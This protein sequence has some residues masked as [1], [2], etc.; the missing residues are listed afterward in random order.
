MPSPNPNWKPGD[1]IDAPF[2]EQ[3]QVDPALVKP[4]DFYKLMIGSI[5]PRPIAFVSTRG[6]DGSCNLSPFSFFNGVSSDPACVIIAIS[7]KKHGEPKDTYR[8]ILDTGEFV[9]NSAN[10]WLI[11]PLVHSAGSFPYGVDEMSKVGLTPVPSVNVKP[12]RVKES[13]V[14]FECVVHQTVAIGEGDPPA[15]L[16]VIGRIVM[17]HIDKDA[18]SGGRVDFQRIKN[19]ARLGGTTYAHVT[20][21]FDIPVPSVKE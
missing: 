5:V 17:G 11:E 9:V 1:K 3:V 21:L 4:N 6:K 8:N 13:A 19:I 12:P 2:T 20:D 16:L 15:T 7:P 10:E 18:Y 14:Q